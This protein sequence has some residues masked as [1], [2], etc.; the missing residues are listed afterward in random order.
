[1]LD[2][3]THVAAWSMNDH[4]SFEIMY[5]YR[6]AVRK[7]RPDFLVRLCSGAMAVVE[8]KGEEPEKDGAKRQYLD[9]WGRALNEHGGFG[10]WH[11]MVARRPGELRDKLAALDS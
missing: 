1:M 6:G 10:E 3:S 5:M 7:H 8:T 4:L 2:E 9:E 11:G